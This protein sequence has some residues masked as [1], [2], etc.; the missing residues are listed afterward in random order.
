MNYKMKKIIS[1]CVI[2]VCFVFYNYTLVSAI[3]PSSVTVTKGI[4]A[5]PRDADYICFVNFSQPSAEERFYIYDVSTHKFIY[6]GLTQ[7]GSGKG[8]T[9]RRAKFSNEI[10]SGCYSLGVYKVPSYGYMHTVPI[11]CFRLKGLS[12]TNSNAEKTWNSDSS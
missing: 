4:N 6:I 3:T 2:L 11:K 7:H 8:N 5:V 12:T 1:I 10:G 9:A